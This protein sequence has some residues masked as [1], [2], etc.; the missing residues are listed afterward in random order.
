MNN[1]NEILTRHLYSSRVDFLAC[2]SKARVWS[3]EERARD[4]RDS[5][6][7]YFARESFWAVSMVQMVDVHTVFRLSLLFRRNL[8]YPE[9][10]ACRNQ[11]SL[12]QATSKIEIT[13]LMDPIRMRLLWLNT[14][15]D[16]FNICLAIKMWYGEEQC[17]KGRAWNWNS[18]YSWRIL[19][20]SK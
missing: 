3:A 16:E 17:S 5:S 11:I 4:K 10:S 12:H 19:K 6:R 14:W 15:S 9:I 7:L 2:F 18:R 8:A 13:N 20:Y 1:E